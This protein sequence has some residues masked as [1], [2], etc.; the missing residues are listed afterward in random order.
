MTLGALRARLM[1][2]AAVAV[3]WAAHT[4]VRAAE[5]PSPGTGRL[6]TGTFPNQYWIIDEATGATVGRIP[7]E[8]GI[9]R[10]TTLSKDK[11]RFYTIEAQMEKVEIIDI[12]ARKTIDK[13]TLSEGNKKVRI[14]SLDPDPT[15]KYLMMV[16]KA[17]TKLID[18]FEIGPSTLLQYNLATH[19]IDRTIPWPNGEERE[20]ANIQFSPDGRLMYLFSDQDVLIYQTTD[21]KQ[22][23]KWELSKPFDDGVGRMTFGATDSAN[24]EPGYYTGIFTI[25]DPVANK[26]LM[27]IGRVNL[28]EKTVDFY[29]LGPATQVGFTM[30]PSRQVAFGLLQEIGRTEFW[31]FDLA[32][33][34]LTAHQE[35]KGRPRMS[36]KTSSNGKVLYVYNAGNTIDLYDAE[37]FTLIKT[38][39]LEGD[40]TTDL[41]VFPAASAAGSA[42]N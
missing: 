22:I 25:Q 9:P 34:K 27:G 36:L 4:Y 8:S 28:T 5:S 37:S 11:T 7:F 12:A 2:A 18:R 1:V 3:F 16:T 42:T 23:D 6:I 33:R 17:A 40:F 20:N 15:N 38:I 13:F 32:Q 39:T 30:A 31:K 19:S 21:F 10:R 35:F 24:D 26:R 41:F 29:T 14:R